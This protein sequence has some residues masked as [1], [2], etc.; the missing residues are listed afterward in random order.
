MGASREDG[1][2]VLQVDDDGPGLR[3]DAAMGDRRGL[4]IAST[5]GRLE[6]LYGAAHRFTISSNDLGGVNVTVGIP[7]RPLEVTTDG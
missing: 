3:A 5:R 1:T 2:L 6:R 4:G 7:Y